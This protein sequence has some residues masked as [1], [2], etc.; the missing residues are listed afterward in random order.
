MQLKISPRAKD[1]LN[2]KERIFTIKEVRVG[3]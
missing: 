1:F 3:G 2:Q